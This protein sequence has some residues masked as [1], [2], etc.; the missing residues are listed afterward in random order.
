MIPNLKGKSFLKLDD[1]SK[2]E[3]LSLIDL[4]AI[5][6]ANKKVGLKSKALE[7][8][9]I[10]ILFDKPST[11]TRCAF[12]VAA[13]DERGSITFLSNSH[14][15]TK[16]S[17]ED[18][19]IVLGRMY[20]GIGY[21]GYGHEV[22][23]GLAQWSGIPVWNGLTDQHHPTQTLATF[24]TIKENLP[25]K[26]LDKIKIIFVGDGNNNVCT[27]LIIGA[28]K[29]GMHITILAPEK[30]YPSQALLKKAKE[31][32]LS[33]GGNIECTSSIEEG[34]KDADAI[35]TDVWVSMGDEKEL[36]DRIQILKPFQVNRAMIEKTQNENV[37]FMHCLPAYHDIKTRVGLEVYEKQGL[38]EMEVTDE[39][40]KSKNSTV[41][42]EAENRLHTIKALMVA[43]IG[44]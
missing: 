14:I 34:V 44:S 18:T 25:H 8:K 31:I 35:Y 43:T 15:G 30:F 20:D 28:V 13:Y 39:V 40:F 16:E 6:K 22:V 10:V 24:L 33:T 21:R 26:P 27:S 23:E 42:D 37:L 1:F 41:F 9:N 19:A 2:E 12:E 32:A 5:K 4:A 11:R 7:G 29:V 36:E 38:Q 3:I 17:V